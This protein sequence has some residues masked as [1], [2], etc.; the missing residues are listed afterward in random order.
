ME[1]MSL[2]RT[3]SKIFIGLATFFFVSCSGS[4]KLPKPADT[5]TSITGSEFYKQAV[6]YNWK[7][8]DSLFLE[9]FQK[10]SVPDF[11]YRFERI[12]ISYQDSTG[13]KHQIQ[14]Y[15]SPDYL[16]IGT[17]EDWARVPVTPMAAEIIA[18]QLNCI[19]PTPKMVD[20][21][22]RQAKVKLEPVPM[23]AYRDSTITM[24]QHHLIIEGQRKNRQG[25]IAGIKKDLVQ[26]PEQAYKGKTDRV[27]IYGWHRLNGS[28][29]QPL[30]TGHINWYVDYS[31]GARLIYKRIRV[32]GKWMDV[33]ELKRNPLLKNALID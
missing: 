3:H 23:Y 9:S 25:L 20:H 22:Y 12:S 2:S 14:F 28:P 29:I 6:S 7:E 17:A 19:L 16:L 33:D 10:G 21:I 27:A 24:W 26:A 32:D 11:F 18:R 8:R 31:H 15:C 4:L 13:E 1:I 30:Y 5:S